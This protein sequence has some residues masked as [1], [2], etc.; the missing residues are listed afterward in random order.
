MALGG[1]LLIIPDGRHG[2]ETLE[3]SAV[4]RTVVRLA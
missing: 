1:D 4:L 3:D 2:V